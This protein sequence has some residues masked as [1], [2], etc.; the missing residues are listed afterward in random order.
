M[1]PST[2]PAPGEPSFLRVFSPAVPQDVND[3]WVEL[4]VIATSSLGV[5]NVPPEISPSFPTDIAGHADV[6]SWLRGRP[7]ASNFLF[8]ATRPIITVQF[9]NGHT[10]QYIYDSPI[11]GQGLAFLYIPGTHYD[12][13][14]NLVS[15]SSAGSGSYAG[16]RFADGN[17]YW[18]Q[19]LALYIEPSQTCVIATVC[20]T[21]GEGRQSCVHQQI[22]Y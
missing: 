19:Q 3:A 10:A 15:D 22:C 4:R 11:A 13:N 8:A 12:E 5:Q 9:A 7:W 1:N 14:G 6:A 2:T 18:I 17:A 21:D 16:M 20:S